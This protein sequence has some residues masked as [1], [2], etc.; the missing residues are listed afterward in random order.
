MM[1]WSKLLLPGVALAGLL[2]GFSAHR[3]AESEPPVP[4][5]S[6]DPGPERAGRKA[7]AAASI[8]PPPRSTDRVEDLAALDGLELYGRLALW[9]T[10]ADE[11]QV[12]E[13][14]AGYREREQRDMWTVD[15]IFDRWTRL[16]PRAAIQAGEG[17]GF[18]GIPWWA[19]AMN[20]PDAALAATVAEKGKYGGHVMRSIGQFHPEMV[21]AAIAEYPGVLEW[22]AVEG[23]GEGMMRSDPQAALEFLI[24][25]DGPLNEALEKWLR[26]DPRAAWQ[27]AREHSKDLG[28]QDTG[29][30]AIATLEREDPAMLR[31][32][33][34]T[35]PEGKDKRQVEAAIFRDLLATDPEA[36]L[37]EARN[38]GAPKLVAERL[39]LIGQQA[40]A[41]DPERGFEMMDELL[42]SL[43]DP[44]SVTQKVVYPNGSSNS[45][46]ALPGATELVSALL[47]ADPHRTFEMMTAGNQ[48]PSP[49]EQ[50]LQWIW[51]RQDEGGFGEWLNELDPGGTRDRG[52]KLMAQNL[53]NRGQSAEAV[54]WAMS[55]STEDARNYAMSDLAGI[56]KH[57]D[58]EGLREW[59]EQAEIPDS[60]RERL[61]PHI[62]TEP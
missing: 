61:K 6:A 42:K 52:A 58:P 55:A 40:V 48:E 29:D 43:P 25:R 62:E 38:A 14:W 3:V 18:D 32:L 50:N 11:A 8:P 21:E 10:E 30:L 1:P 15:L 56:W 22:N 28:Y 41:D 59:Y 34:K 13:F 36:A 17:S 31:E 23:I 26:E 57:S 4:E 19:W 46:G 51:I 12:A 24:A 44:L 37:E 54:E 2:A 20:D 27:W 39:A 47:A 7:A 9:L 53:I 60:M 16:N 35:L 49:A 45:A 33:V 5:A